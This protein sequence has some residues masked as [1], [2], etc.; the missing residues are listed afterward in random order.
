MTTTPSGSVLPTARIIAM[1]SHQES[2]EPFYAF[3]EEDTIL[4]NGYRWFAIKSGDTFHLRL[5]EFM[6]EVNGVKYYRTDAGKPH[7]YM[8]RPIHKSQIPE[9]IEGATYVYDKDDAF[10]FAHCSPHEQ[11]DFAVEVQRFTHSMLQPYINDAVVK[12]HEATNASLVESAEAKVKALTEFAKVAA[13][14]AH[15]Q[16]IAAPLGFYHRNPHNDHK[17]DIAVGAIAAVLLDWKKKSLTDTDVLAARNHVK[18]DAASTTTELTATH[19][20]ETWPEARARIAAAEAAK[21]K[22]E[23]ATPTETSGDGS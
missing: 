12:V 10:C 2:G 17:R 1:D 8:H 5:A 22:A 20:I 3:R 6:E 13:K 23:E 4:H 9:D 21:K 16:V 14:H 7:G 11:I 18:A 15:D 19:T